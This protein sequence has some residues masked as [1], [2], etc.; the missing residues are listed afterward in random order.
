MAIDKKYKRLRDAWADLHS[1]LM[2]LELPED[3][4]EKMKKMS[5]AANSILLGIELED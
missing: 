5:T 4:K 3:I 2:K 1:A